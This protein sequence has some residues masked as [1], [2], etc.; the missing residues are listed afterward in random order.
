[1]RIC[2]YEVKN[3]DSEGT[4]DNMNKNLLVKNL[5]K[6]ITAKDFFKIFQKYGEIKSCKLE[7]SNTGES[8]GYGYVYFYKTEDAE[9]AMKE[10]VTKFLIF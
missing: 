2:K 5:D 4:G 10:L 9:K 6:S 8:K 7:T 3:K 1:V